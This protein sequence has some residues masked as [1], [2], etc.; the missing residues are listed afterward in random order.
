TGMAPATIGPRER[1]PQQLPH[2]ADRGSN[3]APSGGPKCVRSTTPG[4][5]KCAGGGAPKVLRRA[6]E[7]RGM[8]MSH[9]GAAVSPCSGCEL[10]KSK[11]S[12]SS[13]STWAAVVRRWSP[14]KL[15]TR[16]EQPEEAE[17]KSNRQPYAPDW[18]HGLL[19]AHAAPRCR[20]RC[21]RSKLPCKAPA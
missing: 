1:L 16:R 19:H 9:C 11:S 2:L 13:M 20:A 14:E 10:A 6:N 12:K 15:K 18:K 3:S 17:V 7:L 8:G 21:R 4:E 5:A